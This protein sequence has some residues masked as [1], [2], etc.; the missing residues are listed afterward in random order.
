MG[1]NLYWKPVTPRQGRSLSTGLKWAIQR[2]YLPH[3]GSVELTSSD[4]GFLEGVSAASGSDTEMQGDCETLIDA[5]HT[6]GSILV[7]LE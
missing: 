5:I 7:W 3:T 2:K 6:H 1:Q 4:V